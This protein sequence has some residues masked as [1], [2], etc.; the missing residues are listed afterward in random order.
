[1][2][3][4]VDQCQYFPQIFLK[5]SEIS[6]IEKLTEAEKDLI[7]PI[8]LLR[9]WLSAKNLDSSLAK[10]AS[11]FKGRRY[12]LDVDDFFVSSSPQRDSHQDFLK[13]R[14]GPNKVQEYNAFLQKDAN[15]LTVVRAKDGLSADFKNALSA[16]D[17]SGETFLVRFDIDLSINTAHAVNDIAALGH[18]NYFIL[19]DGGWNPDGIFSA[20]KMSTLAS[21]ANSKIP[22]V[23]II[24]SASSFPDSFGVYGKFGTCSLGERSLFSSVRASNNQIRLYYSDWASSRK[25]RDESVPM[26]TVPRVD[27]AFRDKWLMFRSVTSTPSYKAAAVDAM[28]HADWKNVPPSYGKY[29]IE[30]AALG[31]MGQA[32]VTNPRLSTT[33]R[34]NLHLTSQINYQQPPSGGLPDEDYFD[35]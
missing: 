35:E 27:L 11:A 29:L 15:A 23:K 4:A 31:S 24:L 18:Q 13:I 14:H 10:I 6:A 5:P 32:G 28:A 26:K 1:M 21:L 22:D 8:F 25:P 19:I 3:V 20:T 9:P 7:Y 2:Q 30:T 34:I 17:L 16:A 33:A 12:F